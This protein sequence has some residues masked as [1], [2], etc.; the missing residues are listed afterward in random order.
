MLWNWQLAG[1]A[2]CKMQCSTQ[3]IQVPPWPERC[4]IPTAHVHLIDFTKKFML[5]G[6]WSQLPLQK[7]WTKYFAAGHWSRRKEGQEAPP[8]DQPRSSAAFHEEQVWCC[9][10]VRWLQVVRIY[11]LHKTFLNIS[12]SLT[13]L[14]SVQGQ[15]RFTLLYHTFL[16]LSWY[17]VLLHNKNAKRRR[18]KNFSIKKLKKYQGRNWPE[19]TKRGGQKEKMNKDTI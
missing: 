14:S 19:A 11:S 16:R 15:V 1:V 9:C 6:K 4:C 12:N 3:Y 18:T 17:N 5:C 7:S 10:R 13:D 8:T 2:P